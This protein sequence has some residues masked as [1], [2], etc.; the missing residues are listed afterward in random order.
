VFRE[1]DDYPDSEQFA[2][3]AVL[4]L[5]GGLFFATSDAL[6]DRIREVIRSDDDLAGIVLDCEGINF[7]DSQGAAKIGEIV[8]L[9][10]RTSICLRLARVKPEVYKVLSRDGVVARVGADRIHGNVYRAVQ[11][12]LSADERPQDAAP[13]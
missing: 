8:D 2:H 5:D 1:L 9:T 4:R 12:Q 11:A 6:E 10:D 13:D 3:V 7:V